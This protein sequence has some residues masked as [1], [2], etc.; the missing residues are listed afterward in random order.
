MVNNGL[1]SSG[2]VHALRV[3]GET[4]VMIIRRNLAA[5]TLA[6]ASLVTSA[7]VAADY[8]PPIFV[9]ETPEYVPV[10]VGSGWYLRGDLAYDF[11]R[12]LQDSFPGLD[13]SIF[14]DESIGVPPFSAFDFVPANISDSDSDISGSIGFGYHFNDYFRADVNIGLLDSDKYEAVGY[15]NPDT[16]FPQE[17]GCLGELTVETVQFDGAGNPVGEPSIISGNARQGC[18]VSTS[19]DNSAWNGTVNAYADLGTYAGFTP[20]IGAGVGLLY[21]RTKIRMEAFCEPDQFIGAISGFQQ[22][23]ET[24]QCYGDGGALVDT[25]VTY[26]PID[27]NESNY[28]LLY[29]LNAGVAYKFNENISIDVGYQYMNSPDF[30][31]YTISAAGLQRHEGLDAHQV[32]VGLRYDLW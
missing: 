11:K 29:T 30:A 26:L 10:E 27:F 16:N 28:N 19:I 18:E 15:L 8:D 31:S 22:T 1:R 23:T 4:T 3:L 17:Y 12:D 21:S 20:Y 2:L 24:F 6:A 7:A 25:P 13:P 9:E 5:L 32:K 14:R